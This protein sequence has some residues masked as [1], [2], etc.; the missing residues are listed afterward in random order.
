[1]FFSSIVLCEFLS[2]L[3]QVHHTSQSVSI[4]SFEMIL[5][6][7][8]KVFHS[9]NMDSLLMMEG[10]CLHLCLLFMYGWEYCYRSTA[11]VRPKVHYRKCSGKGETLL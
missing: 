10:K 2:C 8:R 6:R 7:S 1:M 3:L 5:L 11:L 4:E 9:W